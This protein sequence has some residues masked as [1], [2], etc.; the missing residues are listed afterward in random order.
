MIDPI[1]DRLVIRDDDPRGPEG[2]MKIRAVAVAIAPAVLAL[3]ILTWAEVPEAAT[4]AVP[5]VLAFVGVK[6]VTRPINQR[7]NELE[8]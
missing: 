3:A 6:A 5:I 8:D 1:V 4:W 7:I 2:W